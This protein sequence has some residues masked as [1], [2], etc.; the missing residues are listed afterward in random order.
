MRRSRLSLGI[1]IA[2]LAGTGAAVLIAVRTVGD[3]LPAGAKTWLIPALFLYAPL[4]AAWVTD[5]DSAP[6][7]LVKPL[8]HKAITD[9]ALFILVILPV[10]LGSWWALEK[11][12]LNARFHAHLPPGFFALALWQFFGVA[13]PEEVFFRGLLQG[14]LNQMMTTR[15][16]ILA[17]DVGPGLFIAGAI[18]AAAHYLVIPQPRQLLVFFPGLL[19]GLFRE[20]SYSVFTPIIAHALSNISF[21]TLQEW[22]VH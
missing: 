2:I 4:I 17:T 18:F 6:L 20:R 10:F 14:R 22:V 7:G 11:Y 1:E 5:S 21:L 15:W 13:L 8:W 19:F 9:L 16:R 3:R 12:G